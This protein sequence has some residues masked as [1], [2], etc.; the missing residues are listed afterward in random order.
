MI[1]MLGFALVSIA[2]GA[3]FA[4]FFSI[5]KK[6]K[7]KIWNSKTR[8]TILIVLCTICILF[9]AAAIGS[10]FSLKLF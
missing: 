6:E 5:S 4:W 10:T 7:S 1:K 2:I 8:L 3:A 9:G